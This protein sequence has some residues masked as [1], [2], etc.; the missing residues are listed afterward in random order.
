[1]FKKIFNPKRKRQEPPG[2][3][4]TNKIT[5]DPASA[6]ILNRH[7]SPLSSRAMSPSDVLDIVGYPLIQNNDYSSFLSPLSPKTP[8]K[9]MQE[10][11]SPPQSYRLT[12]QNNTTPSPLP[13]Q[14]SILLLETS[15]EDKTLVEKGNTNKTLYVTICF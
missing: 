10:V 13:N 6:A 11:A 12:I 5:F 2:R 1:M 8:F 7:F 3:H 4:N 9:A 15:R 14:Q